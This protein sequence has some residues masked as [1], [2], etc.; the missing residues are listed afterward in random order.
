MT[1]LPPQVAARP[2]SL[3]LLLRIRAAVGLNR[4]RSALEES[5]LRL[6][7]T[8]LLVVL[9]WVSLYALFFAIFSHLLNLRESVLETVVALPLVF[10]FFFIAL[11]LMLSFSNAILVYSGLFGGD[12][13]A[14][15]LAAP[16]RPLHLVTVKYAEALFFSS[17]SLALVGLPLMAALARVS[18]EPWYF[19]PLFIS[20]FLFFVPIPGAVGL[21]AAW[22]VAMWSPRNP[23]RVLVAAALAVAVTGVIW[24]WDLARATDAT[25]TNW[26]KSLFARMSLVQ[27]SLWPNTWISLGIDHAL[28]ERVADAVFY[29][30]VTLANAALLSWIAINVVSRYLVTA[31]GR[32]R[33]LPTRVVRANGAVSAVAASVMFFYLPRPLRLIALKD[34]RTFFRDPLQWSQLA[35]LFGLLALYVVNIPQL[36]T[37]FATPQTQLLISFLNFA[38][39]S[40]ILATFTSRFVFPLISLEGQQLWLI[41]LLPLSRTRLLVAKFAFALMITLASA[42]GVMGLS[43]YILELPWQLAVMHLAATASICLGLCGLS[44]GLGAR[45]PVFEHRNPARIASGIG[46]TLNLI[47]S[48]VLVF[49]ALGIM[50]TVSLRARNV[51]ADYMLDASMIALL[52]AIVC[53]NAV[54]GVIAMWIG[55]R[56]F[57][58]REV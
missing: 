31:F 47:I 30:T 13:P 6:I 5:P 4:L 18:S 58:S 44:I 14:Y 48:L 23:R 28:H 29:L 42:M 15:L 17:W 39:V 49:G 20:F 41:G 43:A 16:V 57:R 26:L 9:I 32:A 38:A 2:A 8:I 35:I 34:T 22:A 52:A 24:L 21:L 10:H 12:E 7:S 19:Y 53:M 33:S 45:L 54:A 1:A 40:L 3:M 25:A 11:I 56:H 51:G 27:G 37:N 36:N 55:C 46:G 50:A